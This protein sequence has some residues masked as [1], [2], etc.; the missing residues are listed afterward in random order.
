MKRMIADIDG[1]KPTQVLENIPRD[2]FMM[3]SYI[4]GIGFM[5]PPNTA[6]TK[7]QPQ[8]P[9]G[10]IA[11][12]SSG[13]PAGLQDVD[14]STPT[15]SEK[16]PISLDSEEKLDV[17]NTANSGDEQSNKKAR[18]ARIRSTTRAGVPRWTANDLRR[19]QEMR[20]QGNTIAEIA[21]ALN[22]SENSVT[23][24]LWRARGNDAHRS[25]KQHRDGSSS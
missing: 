11:S 4:F 25:D 24:K 14:L 18:R 15:S 12:S 23:G 3:R 22:R 2:E 17:M 16:T 9:L 20:S 10:P 5:N 21:L 13:F 6:I 8:A 1:A 19:A 7:Y